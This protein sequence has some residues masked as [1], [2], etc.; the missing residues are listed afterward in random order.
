MN[1]PGAYVVVPRLLIL[2]LLLAACGGASDNVTYS[3]NVADVAATSLPAQPAPT[4]S[5]TGVTTAPL[6][7]TAPR[8]VA[9]VL[10]DAGAEPDITGCYQTILERAGVD[11]VDDLVEMQAAFASLDASS[12]LA[13]QDCVKHVNGQ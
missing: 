10:E 6:R 3:S 9:D 5:T 8:S 13:L 2:V 1:P 11:V 12:Q 7:D 4:V